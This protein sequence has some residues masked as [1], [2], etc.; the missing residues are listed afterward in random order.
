MT[1]IRPWG[2]EISKALVIFA[3]IL[4]SKGAADA[5]VPGAMLAGRH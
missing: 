5:G 3:M 1:R 4:M 2:I